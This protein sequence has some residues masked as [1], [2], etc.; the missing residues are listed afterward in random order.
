VEA[1]DRG[2]HTVVFRTRGGAT[3]TVHV[4]G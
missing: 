1:I 2:T 3:R 4:T